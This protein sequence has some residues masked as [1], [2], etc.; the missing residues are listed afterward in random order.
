MKK[1]IIVGA[2]GHGKVV[3]DIARLNGD[4]VI[5][6]LDDKEPEELPEYNII[7]KTN[8]IGAEKDI[9]YFVAIGNPAIRERLMQANCKYYTAIHPRAVVAEDVAIGDGC[10]IMANAVINSGAAVGRGVIVNTA[11]TVDHDCSIS[12]YVHIA[13]G[14]NISGTVT[15]GIRT[16]IGVGAVVSNNIDICTDVTL[17]AGT[18]VVDHITEPGTYVGV[19]AKRIK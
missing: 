8:L 12:D 19:P 11:S 9:W 17:G 3:A 5:G 6:Y 15:V 2:G 7:G 4:E 13:P 14:A 10:C 1:I 18:V 16:W